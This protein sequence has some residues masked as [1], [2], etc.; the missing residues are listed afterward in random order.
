MKRN[1]VRVLS[2]VLIV[3]MCFSLAAAV[4]AAGQA[5]G[6]GWAPSGGSSGGSVSG[7]ASTVPVIITSIA[8]EGGTITPEGSINVANTYSKTYVIKP[9]EGY[10]IADVLVDEVSVGAVSTY[11]F[12]QITEGHKIE[13]IFAKEGTVIPAPVVDD[14]CPR[15]ETCPIAKFTDAS[16]TAW[17]HDGVHYCLETGLMVGTSDSTFEPDGIVTRAQ[18][19]TILYRVEGEPEVGETVFPDVPAGQWYTDAVTWA[20]GEGIVYG[21]DTGKFGPTDQITIEQLI[22]ILN[23]YAKYLGYEVDDKASLTGFPDYTTISEYAI[24]SMEWAVAKDVYDGFNGLLI[25]T[26]G[27]TRAQT[28]WILM[29]FCTNFLDQE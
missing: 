25:P 19:V 12:V 28:A 26:K 27:A 3:T 22:A 5:T 6:T 9:N 4:S 10:V 29:K 17:Y 16:P 2:L 20:A 1:F 8:G 23:R 11:T 14:K 15:D 18:V 21:Y 7:G 24:P 13:A